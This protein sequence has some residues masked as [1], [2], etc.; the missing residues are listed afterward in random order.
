MIFSAL[1][2]KDVISFLA[3]G[4][5]TAF[6]LYQL[7][8]L[9][10]ARPPAHRTNLSMEV[11]DIN[12]LV[13][14][15]NVLLRGVQIGKISKVGTT[16][17]SATI[18]FYIDSRYSIPVDSEARLENLS[19]LGESYINLLPHR[20]GGPLLRDGQRISTERTVQPASVPELASSVVRVLNQLDPGALERIINEGNA[21]LPDPAETLPNIS[22][23]SMLLRNTAADMHGSGR[24]LMDNFQTLLENAS[25]VGP[26]LA[27]FTHGMRITQTAW[28]DVTKHA[29]ILMHIGGEPPWHD[30]ARPDEKPSGGGGAIIQ[31]FYNLVGYRL[32]GF[33]DRY[34]PDLKVLGEAVHPKLNDAAGALMNLDISQLL[35]NM[36]AA[37][38]A[39]G[40]VTL[41]VVP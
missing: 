1:R 36:L 16:I 26:V 27:D 9:T 23:A 6:S 37:V 19:A 2:I 34:G 29:P 30:P 17:D 28:Q 21:A 39:D 3:F 41:H 14:G 13:V 10:D 31:Y 7:A 38:P 4:V 35:D 33:L 22:R 32:Q 24:V 20:D 15:S 5:I 40:T 12:G 18:D 11:S 25:W 8:M